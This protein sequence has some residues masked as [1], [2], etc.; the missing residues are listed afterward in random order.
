MKIIVDLLFAL[1]A[2]YIVLIPLI[3]YVI[4]KGR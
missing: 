2:C 3:F 4:Y 1:T